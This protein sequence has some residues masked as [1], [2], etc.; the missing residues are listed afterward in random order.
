MLDLNRT[1]YVLYGVKHIGLVSLTPI[2]TVL[3]ACGL[4]TVADCTRLLT[5]VYIFFLAVGNA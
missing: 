5:P 2:Y 4:R 3:T 1:P